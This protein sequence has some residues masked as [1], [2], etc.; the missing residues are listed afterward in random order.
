[1]RR[2]A[3]PAVLA[4]LIE[5]GRVKVVLYEEVYITVPVSSAN[6]AFADIIPLAIL[7]P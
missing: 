4:I 6:E 3:R 1:V 2:Y 5:K 7:S